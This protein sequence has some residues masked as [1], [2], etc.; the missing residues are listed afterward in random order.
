MS[1]RQ[2]SA[3]SVARLSVSKAEAE[4]T[5]TETGAPERLGGLR[6]QRTRY[7]GLAQI[8]LDWHRLA[9]SG[10]DLLGQRLGTLCR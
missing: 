6:D 7:F 9:A 1:L 10:T 8:L 5:R 2:V 4:L 3:V